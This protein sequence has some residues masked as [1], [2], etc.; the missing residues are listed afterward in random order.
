M[1]KTAL[2]NFRF[3]LNYYFEKQIK[4][5]YLKFLAIVR[6][7]YRKNKGNLGFIFIIYIIGGGVTPTC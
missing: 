3:H 4:C 1:I 2:K 7:F 6:Y 5:D